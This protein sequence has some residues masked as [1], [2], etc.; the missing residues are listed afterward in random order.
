MPDPALELLNFSTCTQ[1]TKG[2]FSRLLAFKL[3]NLF[4]PV[5][6][7]IVVLLGTNLLRLLNIVAVPQ[8]VPRWLT[9]PLFE[10]FF[11]LREYPI[12]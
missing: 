2:M 5:L 6:L 7:M 12:C 11:P 9:L 1:D 4:S 8:T 3:V 10:S